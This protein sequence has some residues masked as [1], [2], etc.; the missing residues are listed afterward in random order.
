M[1]KLLLLIAAIA[2]VGCDKA[3]SCCP[4]CPKDCGC[5]CTYTP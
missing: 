4:Q 3:S 2:F 1:K 5:G